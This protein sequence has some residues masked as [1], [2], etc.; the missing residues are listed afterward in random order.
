M[1]LQNADFEL[2]S[3]QFDVPVMKYEEDQ[4]SH[5][6]G[7]PDRP[8]RLKRNQPNA[9]TEAIT[10][11]ESPNR[12]RAAG[13]KSS[14]Q[15]CAINLDLHADKQ[16]LFD[17]IRVDPTSSV[18]RTL[19]KYV[20]QRH[21]DEASVKVLLEQKKLKERI[22]DNIFRQ[23]ARGSKLSKYDEL[24]DMEDLRKRLSQRHDND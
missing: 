18:I 1:K 11:L 22:F 19:T 20:T 4:Q 9:A 24:K 13:T 7:S 16:G 23:F 21:T 5:Y 3:A 8:S 2:G 15:S 17:Q 14:M 10:H 6:S 12:L